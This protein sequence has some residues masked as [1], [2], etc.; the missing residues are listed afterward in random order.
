MVP[1]ILDI[2]IKERR[3]T[4][5]IQIALGIMLGFIFLA[6]IVI[7]GFVVYVYCSKNKMETQSK[8]DFDETDDIEEWFREEN[9]N[10]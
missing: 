10:E 3:V 9:K 1:L 6:L 5:V 2:F 8:Y 4:M 7:G